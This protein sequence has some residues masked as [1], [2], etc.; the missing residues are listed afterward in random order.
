MF[1]KLS[2]SHPDSETLKIRTHGAIISPL[3]RFEILAAVDM[4]IT[5]VLG[6]DAV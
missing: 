6:C 3:V 5:I 1:P 2:S 4:K